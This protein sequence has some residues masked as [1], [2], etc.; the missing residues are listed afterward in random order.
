MTTTPLAASNQSPWLKRTLILAITLAIILTAIPIAAK[1]A[2]KSVLTQLGAEYV[3]IEDIDLNLFTGK[4]ALHKLL[5]KRQRENNPDQTLVSIKQLIA[6]ISLTNLI[7]QQL[8]VEGLVLKGVSVLVEEQSPGH[9]VIGIPFPEK[10]DEN[11][12]KDTDE[13]TEEPS[14]NWGIGLANIQLNDV[15]IHYVSKH[16]DSTI[17]INSASLDTAKS[18]ETNHTTHIQLEG[19]ANGAPLH[20][21][22]ETS[23]F[24]SSPSGNL[25]LALSQFQLS[26]FHHFLPENVS[27]FSSTLSL[28]IET[29]I[30][31]D[32]PTTITKPTQNHTFQKLHTTLSGTIN[33]D[34]NTLSTHQVDLNHVDT[35]WTGSITLE[36]AIDSG[37]TI[38]DHDAEITVTDLDLT[39]KD[40]PIHITNQSLTWQG[41]TQVN[42]ADI[43]H[44]LTARG[45][46]I[47]NEFNSRLTTQDILLAHIANLSFTAIAIDGLN[48]Q[49]IPSIDIQRI[50]LLKPTEG[51]LTNTQ[52]IDNPAIIN[53]QHLHIT[54]VQLS[55]F[56]Q[57]AI[58]DITFE[59]FTAFLN[60]DKEGNINILDTV[61]SELVPQTDEKAEEKQKN[62]QRQTTNISSID[63]TQEAAN[64][65]HAE[66]TL[67]PSNAPFPVSIQ[68][69][70][71]RGDTR[72]HITDESV[73]PIF[74]TVV[75][76]N[77]LQAGPI[78][79]ADKTAS[80][81]IDLAG[82]LGE[83]SELLASGNIQAFANQKNGQF[84]ASI[85]NMDLPPVSPYAA[86]AIGYNLSSGQL[87]SDLH[88]TITNNKL[89]GNDKL[90]L[91]NV[92][93]DPADEEKIEQLTAKISM[94]LSLAL[95]ILKNKAGDIEIEIPI[96]GDLNDP[97][98]NIGDV[99]SSSVA[100]AIKKATLTYL[101]FALQPYGAVIM[102][103]EKTSKQLNEFKLSPIEFAPNSVVLDDNQQ[104][105]MKKIASVLENSPNLRIRLCSISTQQDLMAYEAKLVAEKTKHNNNEP[106]KPEKYLSELGR[107]RALT[108]KNHLIEHY[109]VTAN[110]L[111]ICHP[112]FNKDDPTATPRTDIKI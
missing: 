105:Y 47:I 98:I 19:T 83:F 9:F 77:S 109:Q 21:N 58:N 24:A 99:I 84:T 69:F 2:A 103:H 56:K 50:T 101:K 37:N 67:E 104:T 97:Q 62:T 65:S 33:I 7:Q 51:S 73:E 4:I 27:A 91:A 61:L 57:L 59:S 86:N 63:T 68:S 55:D 64:T 78:N 88:L 106:P 111:F 6:N 74:K 1:Y 107:L 108:I 54:D 16:L 12:A 23:P 49:H 110:R 28:N 30:T 15:S 100:K 80:T 70:N 35:Q 11:T 89:K 76:I 31:L 87:S 45:D 81:H 10:H 46:L 44:S 41:S 34:N 5:I 40:H 14:L 92:N 29:A 94:P 72:L 17:T 22:L 18:W 8:L 85:N 102:L 95:S 36:T 66:A 93:V 48:Q 112:T 3:D 90:L 32:T 96:E 20:I 71:L 25:K 82:K 60:V 38:I 75:S 42:S 79:T 13:T 43:E 52:T 26:P 39:L 53:N